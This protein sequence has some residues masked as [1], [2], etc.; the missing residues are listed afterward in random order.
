MFSIIMNKYQVTIQVSIVIKQFMLE[1]ESKVFRM[2]DHVLTFIEDC[3]SVGR[4]DR[5]G[6]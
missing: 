1:V 2:I 3:V 6:Y 5:H 4:W